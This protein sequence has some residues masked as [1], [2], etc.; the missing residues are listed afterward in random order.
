MGNIL[1]QKAPPTKK[2]K[3]TI[4]SLPPQKFFCFFSIKIRRKK[5]G[6]NVSPQRKPQ[7]WRTPCGADVEN[8][9]TWDSVEKR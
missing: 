8:V 6:R 4:P 7:M 1:F 9:H 2:R 5:K 3:Q